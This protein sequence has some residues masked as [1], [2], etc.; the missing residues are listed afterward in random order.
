[1]PSYETAKYKV[2]E[3]E[4]K[5]EIRAYEGYYTAA[6]EE[7]SITETNGFN[8]I[9]AYIS[10]NNASKEKI[11]MTTPVINEL[12]KGNVSTEFVMPVKYAKEG[13]PKPDNEKIKIKKNK[14]KLCAAFS[15]PGKVNE[16]K[17]KES[18]GALIQWLNGKDIKTTGSFRLARYNPPFTP[19]PFRR[20]EILIDIAEGGYE[21]D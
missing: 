11:S 2:L 9:F 13:P 20:N 7:S 5:F 16:E 17:L 6:V 18:E 19:P 3:K 10:G 15:F 14:K 8:Q 1:M 4:G 21:H 12:Q